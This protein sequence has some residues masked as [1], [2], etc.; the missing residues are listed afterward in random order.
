[1]SFVAT[2]MTFTSYN[3]FVSCKIQVSSQN[4]IDKT[5][6]ISDVRRWWRTQHSDDSAWASTSLILW[7]VPTILQL[8]QTL[9]S[10]RPSCYVWIPLITHKLPEWCHLK[11]WVPLSKGHKIM[12]HQSWAHEYSD[13]DDSDWKFVPSKWASQ[14]W[15]CWELMSKDWPI[16]TKVRI[17]KWISSH[18]KPTSSISVV[19][20]LNGKKMKNS[21][22]QNMF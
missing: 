3:R 20:L 10:C 17:Y 18:K 4:V 16:N 15:L 21:C 7:Q 9:S 8:L 2:W 22:L 19:H 6:R 12:Q 1:M 14:T 11:R 5:Y 13:H